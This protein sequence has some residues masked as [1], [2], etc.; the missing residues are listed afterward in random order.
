[1]RSLTLDS[2]KPE[3]VAVMKAG[4]NARCFRAFRA[5]KIPM[6]VTDGGGRN[7]LENNA[8]DFRERYHHLGA[9]DYKRKLR[10]E[11]TTT[12]ATTTAMASGENNNNNNNNNDDGS[13]NNKNA[14]ASELTASQLESIHNLARLDQDIP[15]HLPIPSVVY[16]LLFFSIRMV[17]A[18]WPLVLIFCLARF[19]LFPENALLRGLGWMITVLPTIFAILFGRKLVK[20]F[21]QGRIPP[22]KSAQ[23]LLAERI[24]E[25][26]AIRTPGYDVFFPKTKTNDSTVKRNDDA[27]DD[28]DANKQMGLILYPGWLINHT[29]YAPIASKLSD[30]G[31]L[32]VVMSMEPFRADVEADEKAIK[33]IL[34]VI[35]ELMTDVAANYPVPEWAVGG[36]GYG[37]HL[38]M[39]VAKATSPGTSKLVVWGCGDRPID[40]RVHS[41][42]DNK[43]IEVLVLNGSEDA[44]INRLS[45]SQQTNFRDILPPTAVYRTIQGGNHNGFGHYEKPKNRKRDGIRKITLDEQQEVAVNETVQFLIMGRKA[46]PVDPDPLQQNMSI[47]ASATT[48]TPREV[49]SKKN[50]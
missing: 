31:I 6:A 23:N 30:A 17:F 16:K 19:V 36:H 47:A 49:S 27:D 41:L 25:G 18:V 34:R 5:A 42:S 21:T 13:N 28:D 7:S 32:V 11:A 37:A 39:K 1:V 2:W 24:I 44:S 38:A 45:D 3:H 46:A 15:W 12:T 9:K 29:S 48:V 14:A 40:Y 20:D 4:G 10:N 50:E 33:R 22:F 43:T 26:R 8:E 35:Y